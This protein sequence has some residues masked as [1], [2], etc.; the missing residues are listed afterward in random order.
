MPVSTWRKV[1]PNEF[2]S[3][4]EESGLFFPDA[5][6]LVTGNLNAKVVHLNREMVT[7][8]VAG[9]VTCDHLNC[10]FEQMVVIGARSM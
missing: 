8:Q 3:L 4:L 2:V 9:N 10:G 1:A 5:H 6:V 7:I